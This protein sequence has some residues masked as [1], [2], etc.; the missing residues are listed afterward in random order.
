[1]VGCILHVFHSIRQTTI[2]IIGLN[3]AETLGNFTH[4]VQ[5]RFI[6]K[7]NERTTNQDRRENVTHTLIST[8]KDVLMFKR[9]THVADIQHLLTKQKYFKLNNTND[10][11]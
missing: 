2:N 9:K 11:K 6:S 3:N 1:M 10:Q 4:E 8:A 7:N 5:K